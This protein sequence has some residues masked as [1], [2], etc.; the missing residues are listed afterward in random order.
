MEFG[1]IVRWTPPYH[2]ELNPIE[3]VWAN[4][5]GRVAMDPASNMRDLESKASL[6]LNV[7]SFHLLVDGDQ[8]YRYWQHSQKFEFKYAAMMDEE[9][10]DSLD[11]LE[12]EEGVMD[13]SASDSASC[14]DF[15]L[16]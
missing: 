7:R 11:M 2:P 8:W 13:C 3:L 10:D 5:K 1:H 6:C 16:L 14:D 9:V 15:V 4:I 12:P